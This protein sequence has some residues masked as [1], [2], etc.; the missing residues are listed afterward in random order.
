MCKYY[1][2]NGNFV[3]ESYDRAKPFSSFLPGI[4]G[5]KGI[6]MWVFYVNRAQGIASFGIHSKNN[7]I[8]EFSPANTVYQ[9]IS[10]NGFRTFI[11]INNQVYE[12]F[13][14][15]KQNSF[16][17]RKMLINEAKIQFIETNKEIGLEI[18]VN[19]FGLPNENFAALVR[20]VEI[21]N[22]SNKEIK[23]EVLDGITSILPF[24]VSNEAYKQ[25][26]NLLRSWMEIYNLESNIPFYKLR[27]S[28]NDSSQINE[29]K[30]GNFYLSISNEEKL[31]KPI[32]DRDII[33]GYDTSLSRAINFESNKLS[34]LL[35][36]E[37]VSANKVP[38]GFT[39]LEK[40]LNKN[41]VLVV[42]TLIGQV[43]DFEIINS[44]SKKVNLQ[45]LTKKE[46]ESYN[47]VR[48]LTNDIATKTAS[49]LFD[50]YCRQ[51]YL[52]NLLRGG[53][54]YIIGDKHVYYIYSRKHGDLE[55][56]YNWF[57]LTPEY[58][59]QGN[60][61]YRDTNQNRRNDIFFQPK[62]GTYNIKLFMNL[63]QL[64][65]YNPLSI[66]GVT[67]N[68]KDDVN[69]DYLVNNCFSS[70][71]N[72]LKQILSNKFTLGQLVNYINH[73]NVS[74]NDDE[75]TIIIKILN[76][77]NQNIEANFGEGYWID[78][79]TYNLDLIEAYLA[80]F[81]DKKEELLFGDNTYKYFDSP[82]FVNPRSTKY[83]KN[84]EGKIRQ[85]ESLLINDKEKIKKLQINIHETNWLKTN[86]GS[87]TVYQTNLFV[88]LL[89]LVIVKFASLDPSGI[90]IEMEAD[91]PGWND[92]MNGLPGIFGSGVSET[93][94]LLR[95]INFLEEEK[96]YEISI[97][98]ELH[99]LLLNVKSNLEAYFKGKMDQFTYWDNVSIVKE[100]FREEIRFGINGE[101]KRLKHNEV[102]YII[103][104]MKQ[105]INE[106]LNKAKEI[107]NGI[108]PTYI[109]HDVEEYEEINNVIKVKKFKIRTLPHF[110]EGPARSMKV[111]NDLDENR[112]Q[113]K[114]IQETD[115]FDKKLLMYKTSESLAK[116]SYE[117]GRITAFTPGWLER[118]SIF[119]H[120]TYK[121]LLG[122]LKSNLYDEFFE[123]I[124]TNLIPFLKP[125]IYGRST[126]ENSSFIASSANPDEKL[127]GQ[128]FQARLSGSNAEFINIWLYMMVGKKPF[129]Y[130]ENELFV[131][132]KPILPGWLFDENN[133]IEFTFLKSTKITYINSER[134]DT[135]KCKINKIII[136]TENSK[137]SLENS[138]LPHEYA[139][140][141]REG[142]IKSLEIYLGI[143]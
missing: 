31:I 63:L 33:F 85:Y 3:I 117:I 129:I 27:A 132:F 7:A 71:Q 48:N 38:C 118:E 120:M 24:G 108:Y 72:E 111:I 62:L 61:N 25:V 127:H 5:V 20:K 123:A 142:K 13:D 56:D 99:E 128:G 40:K 135:N 49:T 58:Y 98:Y 51:C 110:L 87:G 76:N 4:A 103:N 95:I 143:N 140:M 92:A 11:K 35:K 126:L 52:D 14:I 107:G 68:I 115:I 119:L 55:R 43:S 131:Q 69:L 18:K 54:P 47:L 15:K 86:F 1:F 139:L 36:Q 97:P 81:P 113:H 82:V 28:T 91:K 34:H 90:G 124:K 2:Q 45:Y 21:I 41:E 10:Y 88:K 75:E 89:S 17:T 114:N 60:G 19:Y 77:S 39:P 37:Q 96:G 112:K 64:D 83:V 6:P 138:I 121:Y 109:I 100:K 53:Y 59:S 130:I 29:I 22:I 101:E 80:I 78:H 42:N 23:L 93:F 105:K 8:L 104:L 137:V 106:G 102:D 136:T 66:N 94:E 30:K 122:L 141:L 125:E 32:V 44:F 134:V 9:N 16:I 67:Y 84:K 50:E 133:K 12:A 74:L 65:G 79:W 57:S 73:H 46:Y 70:R 116:E 26:S